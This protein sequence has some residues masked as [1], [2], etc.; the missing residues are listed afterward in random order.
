MLLGGNC[1][2]S[3]RGNWSSVATTKWQIGRAFLV[4]TRAFEMIPRKMIWN[5]VQICSD[6]GPQGSKRRNNWNLKIRFSKLKSRRARVHSYWMRGT[7]RSPVPTEPMEPMDTGRVS[8]VPG[9]QPLVPGSMVHRSMD[10]LSLL[11]YIDKVERRGHCSIDNPVQIPYPHRASSTRCSRCGTS[12]AR[13]TPWASRRPSAPWYGSRVGQ[14]RIDFS[15]IYNNCI[16]VDND[17]RT[18]RRGHLGLRGR[19]IRPE[20][21]D[22]R[23]DFMICL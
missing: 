3:L 21:S 5:G 4:G 13:R 1:G 2:C 12:T 10:G 14:S 8:V 22:D 20:T 16:I 7:A 17:R 9:N 11:S 15:S 19:S 18:V 23:W 6:V